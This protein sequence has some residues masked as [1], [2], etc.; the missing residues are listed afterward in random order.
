MSDDVLRDL[1]IANTRVK[2]LSRAV[3]MI[4]FNTYT[5]SEEALED[6]ALTLLGRASFTA[7]ADYVIFATDIARDILFKSRISS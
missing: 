5:S 6:V 4:S 3:E 2:V 7:D 1:K